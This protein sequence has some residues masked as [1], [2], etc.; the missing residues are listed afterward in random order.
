MKDIQMSTKLN[1]QTFIERSI[2]KHGTKYG[3]DKSVYINSSTK[4]IVTCKLHGDFEQMAS[5][6]YIA[7]HG[8]PKCKTDKI[9]QLR[10]DRAAKEF[11]AK[12][13]IVHA[14]RY[15]YSKINYINAK[16]KIEIICN[17]H[18]LSF[19]VSPN[20]HLGGQGCPHCAKSNIGKHNKVNHNEYLTRCNQKH[21]KKYNY[22]LTEYTKWTDY[23]NVICPEHG[24]FYVRASEHIKGQG[25]PKCSI[26]TSKGERKIMDWMDHNGIIYT[27]EKTFPDLKGK[28]GKSP[29][30][31]DFFLQDYNLLIEYDGEHHF[32]PIRMKGH[33]YT[34]LEQIK[35][36]DLT[37]TKYADKI[38]VTLLRIKYT[39]YDDIPKIL[40]NIFIDM[41]QV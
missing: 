23:I 7:G 22:D 14:N 21:N 17:K 26:K 35:I 28:D 33:K 30:R 34:R 3:Y 16:H 27:R 38:G 41:V 19:Y 12:A 39:D 40:S 37:K 8:C 20:K 13:T 25:C 32:K 1:T 36:N 2:I 10:K 24:I 11:A 5:D 15:D 31:F 9:S 4:L 6:H 29:L 18:N